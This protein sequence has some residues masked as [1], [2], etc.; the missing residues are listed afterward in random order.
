MLVLKEGRHA[1]I[2]KN[3]VA[4]EKKLTLMN[5][6]PH[7]RIWT[8]LGQGIPYQTASTIIGVIH[9][10]RHIMVLILKKMSA[11]DERY[12]N[13]LNNHP[14]TISFH[15]ELVDLLDRHTKDL[16]ILLKKWG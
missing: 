7:G 10:I 6:W 12:E 16:L 2:D 4:A 8:W 13:V 14:D 15:T 1:E 5:V 3:I 11:G 9:A